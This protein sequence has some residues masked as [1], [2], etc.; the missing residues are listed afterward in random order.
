[1]IIA[2]IALT[3]LAADRPSKQGG[4]VSGSLEAAQSWRQK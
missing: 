2:T 1:L 4:P 3:T